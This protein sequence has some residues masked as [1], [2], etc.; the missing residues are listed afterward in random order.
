[1]YIKHANQILSSI[2]KSW[3]RY[4]LPKEMTV[5]YFQKRQDNAS[6]HFARDSLYQILMSEINQRIF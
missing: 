3:V 1:M 2:V 4:R 5:N 6:V